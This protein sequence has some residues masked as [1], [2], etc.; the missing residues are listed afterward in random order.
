[1]VLIGRDDDDSLY[2]M[3]CDSSGGGACGSMRWVLREHGAI[4]QMS[5]N[6]QRVVV[7][8]IVSDEV[9]AVRVGDVSAMLRNNAFVADIG[10]DDSPR[11]VLT[12]ADGDREVG[13]SAL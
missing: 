9:T 13:P 10:A 7:T 5:S 8:G 4:A 2:V 1:M 6:G 11:V 12:T 3:F